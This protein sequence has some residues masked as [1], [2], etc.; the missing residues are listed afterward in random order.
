MSLNPYHDDFTERLARPHGH[1]DII[2]GL[3]DEMGE[4][5]ARHLAD[6]GLAPTDRLL[7]IGCGSLRAG[8]RLVP[9]LDPGHY[10]GI[11]LLPAL[12]EEGYER[13][14]RPLGLEGRLP[15]ENL[16]A[17]DDFTIPFEG[18]LF[19]KA[20]A[21]SVFTHL[22][23]NHLRLCL[24]KLRPRMREGGT[25]FCTFFRAP[26]ELP[27]DRPM[28][29]EPRGEVESF[30]W[31]DPFHVWDEDIRFAMEGLGWRFDG[32]RDW[33]HPRGQLM[34]HFVAS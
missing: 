11:D 28:R 5:Q 26:P 15:R 7:D 30:G 8:V 33:R 6:N 19:D 13:E 3:W 23:I 32:L 17:T 4:L 24:H 2:G 16:H 21:Q 27:R 10:Y 9:M 18:V 34:G 12:L 22:P 25:F 1:R 29:H 20:L 31:R 14:I